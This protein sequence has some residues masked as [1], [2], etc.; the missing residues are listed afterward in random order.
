MEEVLVLQVNRSTGAVSIANVGAA[1]KNIDGYSILS[2]N[3]WLTGTW[4]SLDDQNLGGANA[5]VEAGP[6][7][8]ALSELNPAQV[9]PG[10]STVNAGDFAE[11]GHALRRKQ[12]HVSAAGNRSR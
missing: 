8:T 5:W 7:P 10:F 4:N 11:S 6:T 3:G 2:P 9:P 1:N 12:R